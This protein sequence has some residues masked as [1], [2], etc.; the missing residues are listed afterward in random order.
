MTAINDDQPRCFRVPAPGLAACL[1]CLLPPI[2]SSR[3]HWAP[4]AT[5][6][7]WLP[8]DVQNP[9]R[10]P[11]AN[12]TI[13]SARLNSN[14]SPRAT[15]FGIAVHWIPAARLLAESRPWPSIGKEP[16][17]RGT[18]Q[19][20]GFPLLDRGTVVL[21][22]RAPW[23]RD[24]RVDSSSA[25]PCHLMMA[26]A[27]CANFVV[28]GK[29]VMEQQRPPPPALHL[30][31]RLHNRQG[32]PRQSRPIISLRSGGS[33]MSASPRPFGCRSLARPV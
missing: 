14:H 19:P 1:P 17:Q 7:M 11:A 8:A 28:V 32:L 24:R 5:A 3:L 9:S 4:P 21:Q 16:E 23:A 6:S 13:H 22:I 15:P 27:M 2:A 20:P 29:R 18:T 26:F 12:A 30:R 33:W 25:P 10:I 31:D